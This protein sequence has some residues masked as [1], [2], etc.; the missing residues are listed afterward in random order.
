MSKKSTHDSNAHETQEWSSLPLN[1]RIVAYIRSFVVISVTLFILFLA[2]KFAA[3]ILNLLI[4]IIKITISLLILY[5]LLINKHFAEFRSS[6]LEPRH[7]PVKLFQS[8]WAGTCSFIEDYYGKNIWK[9]LEN[10]LKNWS[11]S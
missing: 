10:T 9:T 1:Y 5:V 3:A 2:G 7:G 6:I 11:G 8:L 4:P